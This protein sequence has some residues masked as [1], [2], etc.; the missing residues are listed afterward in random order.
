MSSL[1]FQLNLLFPV[2]ISNELILL[3]LVVLE[4]GLDFGVISEWCHRRNAADLAVF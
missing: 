4:S 2:E 3:L 1:E